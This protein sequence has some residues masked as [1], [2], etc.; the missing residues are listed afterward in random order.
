[1]CLVM[2]LEDKIKRSEEGNMTKYLG[3]GEANSI[4]NKKRIESSLNR[5]MD[6]KEFF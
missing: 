5:Y 4:V 3:E 1:M 2:S 6:R